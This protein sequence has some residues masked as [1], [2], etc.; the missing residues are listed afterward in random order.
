MTRDEAKRILA[1]QKEGIAH[2][3]ATISRALVL[4]G[5]RYENR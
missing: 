3:F 5:D 4:T 2:N 1:Q